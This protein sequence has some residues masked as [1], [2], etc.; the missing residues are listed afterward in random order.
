MCPAG[1]RPTA[2][3]EG[4]NHC[5]VNEELV[6]GRCTCMAGFAYNKAGVCTACGQ[7]DNGFLINGICAVCPGNLIYNGKACGCPSGKI[8]Q[9]N[10]CISQCKNDELLDSDGNCYTCSTN[11]V[12]S[13]GQCVC[14]PGFRLSSCGVCELS[15]A[16]GEFSFQ[17]TCATCPLNTIYIES[18][19]GCD[20]PKGFYKDTFGTC[21][22][23]V[24][25]PVDCGE[26]YYFDDN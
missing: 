16:Q 7:L 14:K 26:G 19:N 2:D 6:A 4:C 13:N 12:V 18:I 25:P 21:Q 24:L 9:G 3:G 23:L 10:R 5:R 17:G 8:A 1:S 15:C 22:K 20:C 11:Q